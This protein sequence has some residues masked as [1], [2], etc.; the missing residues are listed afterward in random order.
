MGLDKACY[1]KSAG[2]CVGLDPGK[3]HVGQG[4]GIPPF[5]MR[6]RWAPGGAM[7]IRMD[8]LPTRQE[9]KPPAVDGIYC[10]CQPPAILRRPDRRNDIGIRNR[11]Y[12]FPGP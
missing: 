10:S 7:E 11:P 12:S 2:D 4:R 9:I 1:G 3:V 5:E 8:Y 6:E